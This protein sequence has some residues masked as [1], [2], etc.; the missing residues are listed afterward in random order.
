MRGVFK[1]RNW[2]FMSTQLIEMQCR[3]YSA[4]IQQS[5][6]FYEQVICS[7]SVSANSMVRLQLFAPLEVHS[8]MQSQN[9]HSCNVN[10]DWYLK[11]CTYLTSDPRFLIHCYQTNLISASNFNFSSPSKALVD[12]ESKVSKQVLQFL[13]VQNN[14]YRN[15]TFQKKKSPK[16]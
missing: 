9:Y 3:N 12:I 15:L 11:M 1:R 8:K 6:I 4:C 10:Q 5:D 16:M 13:D 2:K 14:I 7:L